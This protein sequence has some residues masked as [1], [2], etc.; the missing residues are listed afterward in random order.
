MKIEPLDRH[1][2]ADASTTI[3]SFHTAS[4][5]AKQVRVHADVRPLGQRKLARLEHSRLKLRGQ[6]ARPGADRRPIPYVASRLLTG[7][8]IG[9]EAQL[10]RVV[11]SAI[12]FKSEWCKPGKL[13]QLFIELSAQIL[14]LLLIMWI[15]S[16]A[17]C[18]NC[19][20]SSV[21]ASRCR[22]RKRSAFMC[23]R[24]IK[25][26]APARPRCTLR[27]YPLPAR[28]EYLPQAH[29]R[30]ASP[31]LPRQL[32]AVSRNVLHILPKPKLT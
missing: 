1:S 21:R 16:W 22:D 7:Q 15:M 2:P 5:Q 4:P 23:Q 10:R 24:N 29:I 26:S 8:Q 32:P 3:L 9:R 11:L 27:V 12:H 14:P 25:S 28:A 13:C 31:R 17:E 18:E 19:C 20:G 30:A 6:V